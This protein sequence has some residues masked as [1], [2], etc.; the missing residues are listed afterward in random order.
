MRR[1]PK[2]KGGRDR[3]LHQP[4]HSR[5]S[6]KKGQHSSPLIDSKQI[7]LS[8]HQITAWLP[9]KISMIIHWQSSTGQ[10]LYHLRSGVCH[11]RSKQIHSTHAD[12]T[13]LAPPFTRVGTNAFWLIFRQASAHQ[14]LMT[15]Q[16]QLMRNSLID[17]LQFHG[18][19]VN[20][21]YRP[22]NR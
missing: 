3:S 13:G 19:D 14:L 16:F 11:N 8:I 20:F 17:S 12:G 10:I 21:V 2:K 18:F 6:K 7:D 1:E 5:I 22:I 4:P 9:S 15:R